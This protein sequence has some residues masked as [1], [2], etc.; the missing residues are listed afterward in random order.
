MSPRGGACTRHFV[1]P[2]RATRVR[3]HR[4]QR[5]DYCCSSVPRAFA[6]RAPYLSSSSSFSRLAEMLG[7][8][9]RSCDCGRSAACSRGANS[10]GSCNPIASRSFFSRTSPRCLPHRLSRVMGPSVALERATPAKGLAEDEM[11]ANLRLL[12]VARGGA[13]HTRGW[14]V[15]HREWMCDPVVG[16]LGRNVRVTR[17]PEYAVENRRILQWSREP[18]QLG[19]AR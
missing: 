4:L 5:P 14:H 18:L 13:S 6:M 2:F 9:L 11:Q 1:R 10:R 15:F 12:L 8:L 3:M 19:R 7:T 17:L 16:C